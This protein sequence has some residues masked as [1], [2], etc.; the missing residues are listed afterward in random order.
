M[1][2]VCFIFNVKQWDTNLEC[3]KK[4]FINSSRLL[5]RKTPCPLDLRLIKVQLVLVTGTNDEALGFD[6]KYLQANL[7]CTFLTE[8]FSHGKLCITCF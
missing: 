4:E 8:G 6:L 2:T 7:C 5:G 3:L 1:H